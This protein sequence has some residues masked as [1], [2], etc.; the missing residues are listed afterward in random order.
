MDFGE[1]F[2]TGGDLPLTES[3]KSLE[4]T[5]MEFSSEQEALSR[6]AISFPNP[7]STHLTLVGDGKL[8]LYDA[9]HKL[10]PEMVPQYLYKLEKAASQ[11]LREGFIILIQ[12]GLAGSH[13]S[14]SLL[15]GQ[16][17]GHL[18]ICAG[19]GSDVVIVTSENVTLPDDITSKQGLVFK[20]SVTLKDL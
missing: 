1:K 4:H 12:K 6:L 11:F 13:N 5:C 18:G 2:S 10:I 19:L 17:D 9:H 15:N 8:P 20:K 7:R 14:E 3:T 16:M